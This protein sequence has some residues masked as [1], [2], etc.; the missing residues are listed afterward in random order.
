[1][2]T[3]GLCCR[4]QVL[5]FS[6]SVLE[7]LSNFDVSGA[8]PVLLDEFVE[9]LQARRGACLTAAWLP[10]FCSSNLWCIG[11]GAKGDSSWQPCRDVSLMPVCRCRG[12]GRPHT[13]CV[14]LQGRTP[15]RCCGRAAATSWATKLLR[16]PECHPRRAGVQPLYALL[17]SR[18]YGS[19]TV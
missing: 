4:S 14:R 10:R 19:W 15:G 11:A 17:P 3:E 16:W 1:M 6:R 18:L 9:S 8:W 13:A 5:D 2:A 12:Q 7:D